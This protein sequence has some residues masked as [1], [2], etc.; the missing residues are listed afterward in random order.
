M[1]FSCEY[2]ECGLSESWDGYITK[3]LKL[4]SN[5]EMRIVSRSNITVI[6]GRGYCGYFICV[7][8]GMASC[9]VA[10]LNQTKYITEKLISIIG[11]IDAATVAYALKTI[12]PIILREEKR[13]KK[14]TKNRDMVQSSEIRQVSK[15]LPDKSLQPVMII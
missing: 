12:N 9:Q 3:L 5:Y 11:E 4:G 7:P 14:S 15:C 1:I 8:D 13:C 6:F 2:G 10:Y